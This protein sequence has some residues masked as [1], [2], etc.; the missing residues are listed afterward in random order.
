[1]TYHVLLFS[2]HITFFLMH[3]I[4]PCSCMDGDC[5][6]CWN[7]HVFHQL[8]LEHVWMVNGSYVLRYER[9]AH[10]EY[11][12]YSYCDTNNIFWP[13]PRL[14]PE[15]AIRNNDELHEEEIY[16]DIISEENDMES[17][18]HTVVFIPFVHHIFM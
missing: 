2:L 11:D 16:R 5:N 13:F 18:Y 15:W 7:D 4:P 8:G 3:S 12:W 14:L 9:P 1:M 6:Y 10:A 17:K